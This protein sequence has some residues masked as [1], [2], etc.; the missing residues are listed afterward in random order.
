MDNS[1]NDSYFIAKIQE[2]LSFIVKHMKDADIE[3]LSSNELLQD[4]ML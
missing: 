1:K 2:D 3:D 4:S